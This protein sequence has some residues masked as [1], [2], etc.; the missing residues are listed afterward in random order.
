MMVKKVL[1]NSASTPSADSPAAGLA[2]DL[3]TVARI[4]DED[5]EEPVVHLV[6]DPVVLG[7]SHSPNSVHAGEHP[8]SRG[9]RI[10]TERFSRLAEA[11]CDMAV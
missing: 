1:S 5:N 8:G 4:H 6:D 3:A 11:L 9:P 10:V 2:V 7:D